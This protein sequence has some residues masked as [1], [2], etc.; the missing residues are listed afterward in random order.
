MPCRPT[1]ENMEE[2]R[3]RLWV[4]GQMYDGLIRHPA[5]GWPRAAVAR[6]RELAVG[7]GSFP[8]GSS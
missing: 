4:A 5:N 8:K 3:E 1:T 7:S 6:G 2:A